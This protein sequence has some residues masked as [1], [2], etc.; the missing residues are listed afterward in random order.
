MTLPHLAP[1]VLDLAP[2]R[3]TG[4]A[5]LIPPANSCQ[6]LLE[7]KSDILTAAIAGKDYNG[8]INVGSDINRCCV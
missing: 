4:T 7:A 8:G 2:E 3:A 5:K 1:P 6:L